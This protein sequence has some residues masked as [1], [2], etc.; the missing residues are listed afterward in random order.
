MVGL[1]GGHE[2]GQ[3]SGY[4]GF[5]LDRSASIAIQRAPFAAPSGKLREK[6]AGGRRGDNGPRDDKATRVLHLDAPSHDA[7]VSGDLAV[8]HD[9]AT[10]YAEKSTRATT[11]A[12][13]M[14]SWHPGCWRTRIANAGMT[15]CSQARPVFDCRLPPGL[16]RRRTSGRCAEP[17]W[18]SFST[19]A[20]QPNVM[21]LSTG[22]R[23]APAIRVR[24]VLE[25]KP[26]RR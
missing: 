14:A 15:Q 26:R 3:G 2:R 22:N 11:A 10:T 16:R 9:E 1:R 17:R 19:G 25:S 24:G 4:D 12:S 18:R 7:S 23:R 13:L 20:I 6:A 8:G 5:A 21:T